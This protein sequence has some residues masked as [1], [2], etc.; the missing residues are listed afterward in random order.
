MKLSDLRLR[1]T[2]LGN[3]IREPMW[4]I[5]ALPIKILQTIRS[6]NLKRNLLNGSAFFY[7]EKNSWSVF[8]C[9]SLRTIDHNYTLQGVVHKLRG[10]SRKGV[11]DFVTIEKYNINNKL[12]DSKKELWKLCDV[13]FWRDQSSFSSFRFVLGRFR[14]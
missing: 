10:G 14:L 3:N 2:D 7:E 9:V 11:M 5:K 4:T 13:I 12:Y 8:L 1:N 6:A